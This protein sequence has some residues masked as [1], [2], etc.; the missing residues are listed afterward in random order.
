MGAT[1]FVLETK[2]FQLEAEVLAGNGIAAIERADEVFALAAEIG[3]DLLSTILLRIRA[4]AAFETGELAAAREL[5]DEAIA[6][7]VEVSSP[8]EEALALIL[9][10]NIR[11][12]SGGD[13]TADH[14]RAREL[15]AALGV[16]ALPAIRRDEG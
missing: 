7:A 10:G 13:R 16:V 3:D 4:W 5:A 11:R 8:V 15:L 14:A 6:A 9:R 12:R 1:H 2:V